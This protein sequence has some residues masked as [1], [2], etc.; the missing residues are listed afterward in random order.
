MA[1]KVAEV[2]KQYLPGFE[3]SFVAGTAANLG[4]RSSRWIAGD[5]LYKKEMFKPGIRFEDA[6]GTFVSYEHKVMHPGEKAW[7]VQAMSDDTTDLPYR[8]LLPKNIDGLIMGAG[9]SISAED[10]FILRVM[11]HTMVIG[12]AAGTAAAVAV[13]LGVTPSTVEVAEIQ[14]ELNRQGLMI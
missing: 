5:F 3:S 13:R 10:P 8:C 12:Q 9:R 7:S 2:Y 11:A 4:V 6:V 14:A 1:F